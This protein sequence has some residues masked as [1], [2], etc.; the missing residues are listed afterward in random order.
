MRE[1][2]DAVARQSVP[3]EA[4]LELAASG[5]ERAQRDRIRYG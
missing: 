4:L 5:Y 1:T 3:A 2:G